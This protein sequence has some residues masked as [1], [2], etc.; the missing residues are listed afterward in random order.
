MR[1][2]RFELIPLLIFFHLVPSSIFILANF[3]SS[4]FF[5]YQPSSSYSSLSSPNPWTFIFTLLIKFLIFTFTFIF[6]LVPVFTHFHL[7][8]FF[9]QH[10]LS[11]NQP[12]SSYSSL[13]SPVPKHSSSSYSSSSHSCSISSPSPTCPT[14]F[15][16]SSSLYLASV[17]SIS[18]I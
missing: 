4:H 8:K 1:L 9:T 14:Y 15:P 18:L 3:H 2:I 6:Y 16:R 10:I 17:V 12:L 7:T 5:I 11:S 13:F